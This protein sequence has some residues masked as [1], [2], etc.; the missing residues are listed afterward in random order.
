MRDQS[1]TAAVSL[2]APRLPPR[3][4]WPC[5]SRRR[6]APTASLHCTGCYRRRSLIP[7]SA[8]S[9]TTTTTKNL[10]YLQQPDCDRRSAVTTAR[11]RS[12]AGR[13]GNIVEVSVETVDGSI[14][15]VAR[16]RIETGKARCA[17]ALTF[18]GSSDVNVSM[19]ILSRRCVYSG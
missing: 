19:L 9:P 15:V 6:S 12:N 2:I 14:V 3:P 10:D 17:R 16:C 18:S 7:R 8:A 4:S 13:T 5:L 1:H 11:P